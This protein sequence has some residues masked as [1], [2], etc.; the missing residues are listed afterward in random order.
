[1]DASMSSWQRW[2]QRQ[3][4]LDQ[5]ADAGL[6]RDNRRK[7]WWSDGLLGLALLLGYLVSKNPDWGLLRSIMK[8]I[9][10]VLGIAGFVLRKWASQERWFLHSPDP[11]KPPSIFKG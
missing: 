1:M 3:Q 11:E 9:A 2:I 7:F 4:E 5:G 6:I 10:I 8:A